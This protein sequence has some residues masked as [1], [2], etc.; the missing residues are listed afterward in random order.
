M[1]TIAQTQIAGDRIRV[2]RTI[3][4]NATIVGIAPSHHRIGCCCYLTPLGLLA[5]ICKTPVSKY[6]PRNCDI[7]SSMYE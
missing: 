4:G 6:P 7:L 1:L 5:Q 2:A 3:L